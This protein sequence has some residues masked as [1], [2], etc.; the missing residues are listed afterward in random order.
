M[1]DILI[2]GYY[3]FK[4]SGDDALLLSI[5]QQL[6]S[7]KEDL[8][9]LVLSNNPEETKNIYKVS[10]V[11]RNSI[12]KVIS[13]IA[14]TKMLLV[15]GGTLIQDSTSTKSLLYYLF[16]I[17]VALLFNKKVMLYANGIGPIKKENEKI[18][19]FILNKVDIITLRD[20][21]SVAQLEVLKITKPKI[22]LTADSAFGLSYDE[23][24]KSHIYNR[25]KLLENKK[26][27]CIS[28]RDYK[29]LCKNFND[30]IKTMCQ[31]IYKEFGYI[32]VFLP[33]QPIKDTKIC[34]DISSCLSIPFVVADS[35]CDISQLLSL[36][37]NSELMVGM[38]LHSLIYST[39]CNV[40]CVGLVYDPKVKAF[41]DYIG[42][43]TYI[44]AESF[45]PDELIALCTDSINNKE[46]IK[47]KLNE[48]LVSL[49]I[50]AQKNAEYALSLLEN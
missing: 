31:T 37:K 4:N 33:F 13:S 22:Y 15:G 28:L 27:F 32:P 7:K 46:Q 12:I 49:K 40:S 8:K 2:L 9:C 47:E 45:S 10:S 17:A 14:K 30:Y 16:I 42:Q 44:N 43:N 24:D 21:M 3:G 48:N 26:Y 41:M 34:Q 38:R 35:Q 25:Y 11:D 36:I 18:T 5:I 23:V 1:S 6:Y 39:I 50:N 20:K 19:R 29:G